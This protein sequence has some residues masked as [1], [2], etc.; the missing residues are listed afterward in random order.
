MALLIFSAEEFQWFIIYQVAHFNIK[1][2]LAN[3]F[4][5]KGAIKYSKD[6]L[7]LKYVFISVKCLQAKHLENQKDTCSLNMGM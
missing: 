3:Q 7:S 6:E 5:K 2:T 1:I 4:F